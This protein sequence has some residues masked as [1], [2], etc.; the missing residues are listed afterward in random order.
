MT[1]TTNLAL[2]WP[3][4][5]DSATLSGG[6]WTGAAITNVQTRVYTEVAR[7]A[8]DALADTQF[9]ADLGSQYSARL[10]ALINH[11]CSTVARWRVRAMGQQSAAT[12]L[13]L[14]SN[15]FGTTWTSGGTITT[16]TTT[17]PDGG[18]TADTLTATGSGQTAT[19][20]SA[21]FS[22]ASTITVS[23]FAKKLA[24]N[25]LRIS[26]AAGAV[27][28][29][30]NLDTGVLGSHTAGSGNHLYSSSAIAEVDDSYSS[31]WYRCSLTITTAVVTTLACAFGA[32]AADSATGVTTNSCYLWEAQCE[33]GSSATSHIT[34]AGTTVTRSTS[35]MPTFTE[36][37]YDS[38]WADVWTPAPFGSIDWNDPAFWAGISAE[39]IANYPNIVWLVMTQGTVYRFVYVEIDDTTNSDTYVEVGRVF[40]ADVFQ[41]EVNADYGIEYGHTTNTQVVESVDGTEFFDERSVV[42]FVRFAL[43]N[44]TTVEAFGAGFDL[45]RRLG[46]SNELFYV[47]NPEDTTYQL[48]KG[49]PGRLRQLPSFL[50][51]SDD[52]Q[53]SVMEVKELV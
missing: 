15:D 53:Q 19:Q 18:S 32:V 20:T 22:A 17:D 9:K 46:I 25:W 40:F 52:R 44:L 6:S 36:P 29:W 34:T 11:N 1:Q 48:Q 5:I 2:C 51:P 38:G 7:S 43:N 49:F 10:V 31:G 41:P 33:V 30:Y 3:N 39:R 47:E 35:T 42:R 12:N 8:T 21:A 50:Q 23:V 37:T 24:S 14:R 13:L 16:N 45:I 27:E 4:R 28:C 26:L